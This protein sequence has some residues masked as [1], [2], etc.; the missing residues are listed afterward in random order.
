MLRE[1]QRARPEAFAARKNARRARMSKQ[2]RWLVVV[3][4]FAASTAASR[5]TA[6]AATCAPPWSAT[7]VYTGSMQASVNGINYQANW[8]TQ[9]DDPTTHHGAAGSGQP[10]TSLGACGGGGAC[11]VVPAAPGG[12]TSPSQTSK[13]V[14]LTW[15]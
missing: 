5:T 6:S 12:L 15:S 9:G 4:V 7:Q 2:A 1:Q 14:G 10:W 8:W 11:T 13:S 3:V